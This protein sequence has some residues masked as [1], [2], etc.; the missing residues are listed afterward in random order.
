MRHSGA[1]MALNSAPPNERVRIAGHG[2]RPHQIEHHPQI[3]DGGGDDQDLGVALAERLVDKV[4]QGEGYRIDEGAHVH[5]Q[6][7][8]HAYLQ[9][10]DVGHHLRGN[11]GGHDHHRHSRQHSRGMMGGRVFC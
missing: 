2:G 5:G 11:V 9:A 4:P 3:D 6:A 7:G 8:H 1:K 10:G